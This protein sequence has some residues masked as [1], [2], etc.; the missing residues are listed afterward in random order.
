[1]FWAVQARKP[2]LR[3]WTFPLSNGLC[4]NGLSGE[5]FP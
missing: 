5:G 4:E 1:M 2:D 3:V